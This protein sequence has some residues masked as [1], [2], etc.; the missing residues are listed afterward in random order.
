[1]T[2]IPHRT[3]MTA[4][5]QQKAVEVQG[6][7]ALKLV[8]LPGRISLTMD[9]WSSSVMAAYIGVTAHYI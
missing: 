8:S 2:D 9:G 5:I 4:I 7:L 3:T 1:E 6:L